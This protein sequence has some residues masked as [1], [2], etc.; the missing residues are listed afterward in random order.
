M[1]GRIEKR[2]EELGVALP[3]A[4]AP[5]GNYVPAVRT[6]NLVFVSGQ[7]PFGAD[8]KLVHNGVLGRDVTIEQGQEAA[9]VC[10]INILAQI[11]A[12]TGDLDRIARIVKITGFVHA[13]SGFDAE[14]KVIN[15]TSDFFG[16][17]FGE[18]GRHARAAVGVA[19][20]PLG[21]SVEVE[22][23]VEISD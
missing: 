8:G 19:S 4:A 15:G 18:A 6:G 17:V 16:E 2:L 9:K 21:V 1:T 10:A 20:L 5:A 7:I 22:A 14:P 12:L 13:E 3:A 23:I 11:K